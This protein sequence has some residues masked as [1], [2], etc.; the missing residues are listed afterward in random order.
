[1]KLKDM[2]DFADLIDANY[3]TLDMNAWDAL[4]EFIQDL[5]YS[6]SVLGHFPIGD[7]PVSEEECWSIV[8]MLSGYY[9][10]YGLWNKVAM[11]TER[12]VALRKYLDDMYGYIA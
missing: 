1:M 12:P 5:R 4:G 3:Y 8:T 6:I 10:R 2:I 9:S 7:E 11:K